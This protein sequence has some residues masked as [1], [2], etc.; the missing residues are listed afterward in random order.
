M[1][2]SHFPQRP[3]LLTSEFVEREYNR[4]LE[5]ARDA[6]RQEGPRRWFDLMREWNAFTSYIGSEGS[7]R[8]HRLN[9]DMFNEEA[10]ES[11][12]VYRHAIAPTFESGEERM[13]KALLESR[14]LPAIEEEFGSYRIERFRVAREGLAAVNSELR[15]RE[16]D[17]TNRYTKLMAGA[18]VEFEGETLSLQSVGSRTNTPDEEVRKKA[19][20]AVREFFLENREE[21][22][23]IFDELVKIR[24]KM[25]RNL[26]HESYTPLGYSGMLRTDYGPEEAAIFRAQI[27]EHVVPVNYAAALKDAEEHGTE[28]MRPWNNSY[29]PSRTIPRGV[30][31]VERQL[32]LAEKFFDSVAPQL[33]HHFRRMR[34]EDLI[35]LENRKGK[36][37]GAYCTTFSDEERVAILCNSVGDSGDI[38]TLIHEMGHAF[39]GWESQAIESVSLRR[40]TSDAAE[41]HSMG[42]EHIGL[43]AVDIFFDE[44]Q[45]KRFRRTRLI[46]SINVLC[47]VCVVDEFQHWVY[48]HPEATPRE[49]EENWVRIIRT[50]LPGVDYSGYEEFE[51]TIWYGQGHIFW[52]PFYYI[53]YAIAEIGA[54]QL[55]MVDSEDPERAM[56][57]YV[58][59]CRLGG[60]KSVVGIFESAGLRPPFGETSLIYEIAGYLAERLDL[61]PVTPV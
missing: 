29:I 52:R 28:R 36:R 12:N 47:Y 25:A 61:E 44:E 45:S 34:E 22:G 20:S 16:R 54:I 53:D 56:K 13:T 42:M 26:G 31:P 18:E 46:H 3:D 7:R 50:Y 27:L 14:H 40:P 10:E 51:L 15:I 11:M 38:R 41:L 43:K 23:E 35:D 32:D 58:D 4:M 17:L 55:G 1:T 39:Q 6:E 59:L 48:E 49:R 21:L 57:S 2:Y 60:Q 9:R 30:V 37:S 24:H 33:S 19:W 5:K 8:N